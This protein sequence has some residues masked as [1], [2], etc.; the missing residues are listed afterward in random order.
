MEVQG[1]MESRRTIFGVAALIFFMLIGLLFGVAFS[2]DNDTDDR[3]YLKEI[4]DST[5]P[6]NHVERE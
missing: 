1:L 6:A 5:Q 3:F 2:M 4:A